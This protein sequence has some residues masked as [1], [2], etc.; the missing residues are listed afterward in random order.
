MKTHTDRHTVTDI[1]QHNCSMPAITRLSS[2]Y[3]FQ[4]AESQS[5]K[6]YSAS[7]EIGGSS[8]LTPSDEM[9]YNYVCSGFPPAF[10]A[11]GHGHQPAIWPVACMVFIQRRECAYT[12]WFQTEAEHSLIFCISS[13]E[14]NSLMKAF[15][16]IVVCRYIILMCE[17]DGIVKASSQWCFIQPQIVFLHLNAELHFATL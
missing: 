6:V 11:A 14:S 9:I 12:H 17:I 4:L 2:N 3:L 16:M 10:W 15:M 5:I 8:T 13:N 7:I 1:L